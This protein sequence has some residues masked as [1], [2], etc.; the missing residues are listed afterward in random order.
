M[1]KAVLI[2]CLLAFLAVLFMFSPIFQLNEVIVS[3]YGTVSNAEIR[4][5]LDTNTSTNLLF[6][7]TNAARSRVM[8]NLYISDVSFTR[9]ITNRRLYVQVR[10]RRLAAFV[11]HTPGSFLY[12]D[13]EGRV[14]EVRHSVSQP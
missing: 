10:E 3:G 5:R 8:E 9:D 14:L 12:I 11:E 4:Q 1:F 13:D 7:N 2:V 6:F